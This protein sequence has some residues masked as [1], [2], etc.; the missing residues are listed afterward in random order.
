MPGMNGRELASTLQALRPGLP[1]LFASG[2]ADDE[3]LLGD[4][5]S[6]DRTFL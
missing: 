5:R 1:V 2:Y 6:D 4:L 3:S